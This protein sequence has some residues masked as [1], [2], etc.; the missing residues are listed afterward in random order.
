MAN[1][2]PE[3]WSKTPNSNS[4]SDSEIGM[5][6]GM[7]PGDVNDGV[8]ALMAGIANLLDD[9]SGQKTTGGTTT[10]YTVTLNQD[11]A[12][13]ADGLSVRV[14][15]NASSTGAFTFAPNGLTAKNVYKTTSSGI[16]A[17]GSGDVVT[18][19]HADFE[20]DSA[21]NSAAG[22]WMLMNP[23]PASATTPAPID[24]TYVT[25][26]GNSTLSA[27]RTLAV[28]P[29]LS[30]TDGGAGGAVT[31][32]TAAHTGDVTSSANSQA[33]T[34]ASSA[35]TAAKIATNAVTTTKIADANVTLAKIDDVGS[36]GQALRSSGGSGDF[37]ADASNLATFGA[38][39]GSTQ[40]GISTGVATKVTFVTE[41]WDTLSQYD[42]T[43]SRWTP[44]AGTIVLVGA[45]V[46]SGGLD[47]N[48]SHSIAFYKNGSQILQV[49]N[50]TTPNVT[51][52]PAGV[53]VTQANGTDYFEMYYT[54]TGATNKSIGSGFFQ[55][56]LI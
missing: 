35:V 11:V 5:A 30:L 43:N 14:K 23:I 12:A 29:S 54:G 15:I 27:E 41:Q 22:G 7:D 40:S 32:G 20:Y 37:T 39:K 33:M 49:V 56:F 53:L 4:N 45:L 25:L 19:M 9:R 24:A 48:S 50:I 34:I 28:A 21:L 42:T 10:A 8:R 18:G 26:T 16:Q 46:I 36:L 3:K 52:E 47:A 17:C 31:I 2:T 51:I 38:V 55:G 1:A 44:P 6:E 13:L